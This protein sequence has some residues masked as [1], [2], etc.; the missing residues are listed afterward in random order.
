MRNLPLKTLAQNEI[1]LAVV[2]L[3]GDLLAWLGLLGLKTDESRR[4][5]PK[6]LRLRL[7]TAPAVIARHARQALLHIKENYHWAH[8]VLTAHQRLR[9]LAAAPT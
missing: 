6:R 7:F 9:G 5:E 4:W 1:W 2:A 8:L 3:A